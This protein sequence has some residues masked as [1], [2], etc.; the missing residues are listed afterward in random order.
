[1]R[2][3]NHARDYGVNALLYLLRERPNSEHYNMIAAL[4]QL[5]I[6]QMVEK[7]VHGFP[8][9]PSQSV[10]GWMER[11]TT[12]SGE[13]TVVSVTRTVVHVP[14]RQG[15]FPFQLY[16][17]DAGEVLRGDWGTEMRPWPDR[18]SGDYAEAYDP[19]F[20]D[21]CYGLELLCDQIDST[22]RLK[23]EREIPTD[24]VCDAFTHML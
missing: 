14:N 13:V 5:K 20:G 19:P 15:G 10:N 21:V 16:I 22:L 17:T 12:H 8:M 3:P 1:M 2:L 23:C 24:L 18:K 9:L 7:I 4:A 6:R 11:E